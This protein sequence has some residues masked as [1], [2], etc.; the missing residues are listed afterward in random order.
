MKKHFRFVSI[1]W[2]ALSLF[3][4]A[5]AFAAESAA[6][7]Q[8][9]AEV[10]PAPPALT[11]VAAVPTTPCD[12]PAG[13]WTL[14]ALPDTQYYSHKFPQVF[15][16]QT[17]WI[18]HNKGPWN[19][20]FVV[21]EGDITGRNVPEDWTVA[22]DA[23]HVLNKAGIPYALVP[24]N[25]D[26]GEKGKTDT[27]ATY[28]N[29]YFNAA[30]Y[31]NSAAVG[32]F[33]SGKVENSWHTF[34]TPWGEFMVLALEFGPRAAVVKWANEAVSAH[35]ECQVILVTHAYLMDDSGLSDIARE[36]KGA[37]GNPR[38]YGIKDDTN[39]GADLWKKLVSKH[40]NFHMVLNGHVTGKGVGYLESVGSGGQ[41]VHQILANYQNSGGKSGVVEPAYSHGGGGF[42]RLLEFLP[43]KKTVR[44][45]TYSPWFN[46]W[47]TTPEQQFTLQW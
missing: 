44:V 15:F 10:K 27:R 26:L 24:G 7:A 4:L 9:S 17:A 47:L 43:D 42:L 2:W 36:G 34:K 22:R 32:F 5:S 31:K 13:T 30:D 25:H 16:R 46:E 29:D 21:Q 33:E 40:P 45:R 39:D 6:P 11:P 28:M 37:S 20:L 12:A 3:A 8:P 1:K 18:A 38:K 35:P 23:M 41:R 14:V 19:I